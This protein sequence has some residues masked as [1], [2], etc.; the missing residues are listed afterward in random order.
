M[1]FEYSKKILPIFLII[2]LVCTIPS[3]SQAY[4]QHDENMSIAGS[5]TEAQS[6]VSTDQIGTDTFPGDI[7]VYKIPQQLNITDG[8]KGLWDYVPTHIFQLTS[9]SSATLDLNFSVVHNGSML[10]FAFDYYDATRAD[11][12]PSG[13]DNVD[14]IMDINEDNVWDQL[15]PGAE[16]MDYI[17]GLWGIGTNGPFPVVYDRFNLDTTFDRDINNGGTADAVGG[18]TYDQA[19]S[20]YFFEMGQQ[21]NSGDSLD[22]NLQIGDELMYLLNVIVDGVSYTSGLPTLGYNFTISPQEI[23]LSPPAISYLAPTNNTYVDTQNVDIVFNA[24]KTTDWMGYSLD[25]TTNQTIT[26][27]FSLNSLS[28]GSHELEI[29][30]NDT[31]GR[32]G[33]SQLLRFVIDTIHPEI[34]ID[35]PQSTMTYNHSQVWLNFTVN[36]EVSWF[37]Y[38]LD[39]GSNI[40]VSTPSVLLDLT[41]GNHTVI[42]YAADLAGNEGSASL[43][44]SVGNDPST[45][46]TSSDSSTSQTSESSISSTNPTSDGSILPLPFLEV[47]WGLVLIL[48]LLGYSRRRKNRL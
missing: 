30:A 41:T 17:K 31:S 29:F 48:G 43:S 38:G 36:E 44:I 19:S 25:G 46:L 34:T 24:D 22:V 47:G 7:T 4:I 8:L 32:M 33:R 9:Q 27:N 12:N 13:V 5:D 39:G 16:T 23:N 6:Q 26:G 10:F 40:S 3:S 45:G 28:E 42:V 21:F 35:S 37:K 11:Q 20:R 1:D 14:V 18:A 15:N 2:A